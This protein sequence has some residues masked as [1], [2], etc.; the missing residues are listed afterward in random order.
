MAS[1]MAV[2]YLLAP[3]QAPAA[4][5]KPFRCRCG[6]GF[7][8]KEHLKRHDLLVHKDVRRFACN[9]CNLRF[10]TK[11]NLSVHCT[12]RKHKLRVAFLEQAG[13]QR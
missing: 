1:K 6:R 11:Q 4:A 2:E 7:A 13:A 12:T 3:P 8:K 9:A 5:P 10:G